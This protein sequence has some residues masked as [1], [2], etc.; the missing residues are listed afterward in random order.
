LYNSE[1]KHLRYKAIL[2]SILLSLQCCE[3]YFFKAGDMRLDY[4]ILLK[5]P[6]IT[7]LAGSAP[8]FRFRFHGNKS[9]HLPQNPF[10]NYMLSTT[11]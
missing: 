11:W 1:N 4:Q 6:F 9:R 2:S 5:S 3:V 10:S 7:L 8:A